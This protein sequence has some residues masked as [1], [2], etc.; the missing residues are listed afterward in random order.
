MRVESPLQRPHSFH[1]CLQ[2]VTSITKC[3]ENSSEAVQLAVIR[4]L[5]TITTAEHFVAH[6][7]S[8]MQ[9]VRLHLSSALLILSQ[10]VLVFIHVAAPLCLPSHADSLPAFH[11]FHTTGWAQ[12][13]PVVP[14][15]WPADTSICSSM[16]ANSHGGPTADGPFL[17]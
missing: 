5:L 7:E 12:V 9:A 2:V 17:D 4:A 3:G 10:M 6:G 1:N 8:L 15:S 16:Y 14:Q 13:L 11:C